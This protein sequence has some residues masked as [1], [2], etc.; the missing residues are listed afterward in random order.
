M[1]AIR[2]HSDNQ[3]HLPTL[4]SSAQSHPQSPFLQ[5]GSHHRFWDEDLTSLGRYHATQVMRSCSCKKGLAVPG[6][7][8]A[9]LGEQV[10][11]Q[12]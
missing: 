3:G 5:V 4:R 2:V 8:P 9:Q 12:P 7:Y 6:S 11:F 1:T 10:T